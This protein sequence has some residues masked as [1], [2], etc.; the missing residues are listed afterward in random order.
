MFSRVLVLGLVLIPVLLWYLI[1]LCFLQCLC[2][3]AWVMSLVFSL[4]RFLCF[5]FAVSLFSLFSLESHLA[6]PVYC[7]RLSI[8]L[9]AC[10]FFHVVLFSVAPLSFFLFLFLFFL[11]L[12]V[13]FLFFL[14]HFSSV[15]SFPL[16]GSFFCLSYFSSFSS[17]LFVLTYTVVNM[18]NNAC[19]KRHP[20]TLDFDRDTAMS[21]E[22][23]NDSAGTV[24]R[25]M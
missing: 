25:A 11:D 10:F 21:N 7:G 14:V 24:K 3:F 23:G 4:L 20:W 6:C 17:A 15:S 16:H 8:V 5:Q 13:R 1:S 18:H 9:G 12:F 2:L 22:S 19:N